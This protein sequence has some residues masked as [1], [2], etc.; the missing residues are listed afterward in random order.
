MIRSTYS[1]SGI[2]LVSIGVRVRGS[3][4]PDVMIF[5]C[6]PA[7]VALVATFR[8]LPLPSI[9]NSCALALASV[10]PLLFR[11]W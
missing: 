7:A 1:K 3:I 2:M 4:P 5:R 8:D 6:A 11:W 9:F 10:G